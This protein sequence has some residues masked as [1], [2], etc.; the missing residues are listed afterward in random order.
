M[1]QIFLIFYLWDAVFSGEN[2]EVFGYTRA[3]I[4]TY[5]F[6]ILVLRALVFS[7]RA[8]DVAGE[9]SR[10]DLT[11]YLLKPIS[12]FKYWLTRDMSSKFLNI[13]FS[14]VEVTVLY[15]LLRPP[16]FLQTD[17][18]FLLG[19]LVLVVFAVLLFFL[20]LFIVNS[21]TLWLPEA[22]WAGQFLFIVIIAEFLSGGIFPLDVLPDQIQKILYLLPFPYL[23]FI[24]LQVYLGKLMQAD[25]LRSVFISGFWVMVLATLLRKIWSAGLQQYRAEGR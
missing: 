15:L 16:F 3:T 2:Q 9:I 10:G 7:A 8:V 17:L 1:F 23:L 20:I 19:F 6:G 13:S 22:G 12:Y 5:V 18:Y 4:L 21:I 25:L 14:V 24:P 11:N